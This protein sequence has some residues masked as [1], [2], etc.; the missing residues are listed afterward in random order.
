MLKTLTIGG[1]QFQM[2]SLMLGAGVL[3]AFFGLLA[4]CGKLHLKGKAETNVLTAF[5]F[6]FLV[7]AII[8]HL[9]DV[10]AHGGI[11]ALFSADILKYGIAFNGMLLGGIPYYFVHSRITKTGFVY[12]LDIYL[13]LYAI[14]QAF[15]RIGCF[16]GGC[17]YGMP[18]AEFGCVY[19]DGS[20]PDE[21]Y[22]GIPLFPTQLVEAA[23]LFL[24]YFGI[25]F[26]ARFH[27]RA[28]A[29]LLLLSTGRFVLEFFRGD[30][31]GTF[32]GSFLSPAQVLSIGFF[33][34]GMIL[35]FR[36]KEAS[37]SSQTP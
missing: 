19:P 35:L 24:V 13:P 14:A 20:L 37:A 10:V 33:I 21:K 34:C 9:L 17:C 1:L 12:L 30:D 3:A 2:F 26:F 15:G 16:L 8:A 28:A 11:A 31:R 18:C 32:G 27:H 25:R 22:H 29:Y 36:K 23:W 5:P 4:Q 6:A 7:G